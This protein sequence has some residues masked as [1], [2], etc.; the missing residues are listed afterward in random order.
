MFFEARLGHSDKQRT[1]THYRAENG[2]GS[3][4]WR[5]VRNTLCKHVFLAPPHCACLAPVFQLQDEV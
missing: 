1:D 5:C 2:I 3:F 4:N